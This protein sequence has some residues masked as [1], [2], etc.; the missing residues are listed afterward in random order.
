MR[1]E[2]GEIEIEDVKFGESRIEDHVL[3]IDRESLRS[4]ILEDE[5]IASAKVMLAKPGE[6]KR[7]IPVKDVIEPRVKVE[8]SGG[9]FPGVIANE[10]SVGSGKTYVVKNVVVVTT[11]QIVGYQEGI[12]DMTGPG[13]KYTPFSDTFNII[14]KIDP[15]EELEEHEHEEAIR[16]AGLKVAAEIANVA[17]EDTPDIVETYETTI[18]GKSNEGLPKVV[19]VIQALAQG[20]LHDTYLYGVDCKKILPT[21]LNPLETMDGAIVSGNCVSACDKNTTYHH[22]NDPVVEELFKEHGKTLHFTGIIVSP[23][24]TKFE[25]KER[26]SSYAAKLADMVG[27]DGAIVTEEG[28]GNPEADLMLHAKKLEE[29]GI[30]TVIMGDEF[31][32]RDGKS[33]GIADTTPEADAFV[34][35]GNANETIELPELEIL[36]DSSSADE[37]AGRDKRIDGKLRVELQ[38]LIG[39][40]NGLGYSKLTC[41]FSGEDR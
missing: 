12:I 16:L 5:R 18:P 4:R 15:I 3:Y 29:R 23:T 28:F 37:I 25:E 38:A 39:S 26:C 2:I 22:Q 40:T 10:D 41:R 36:G 27:A 31:A 32:G 35:T 24:K 7:I 17:K 34:S 30:K 6:R 8:G 20:L 33:Q 9:V 13:A 14:L 21:I 11:G 1:L 19:Y